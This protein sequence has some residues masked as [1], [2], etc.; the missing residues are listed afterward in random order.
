MHNRRRLTVSR[1][2]YVSDHTD[3]EKI[4]QPNFTPSS[5]LNPPRASGLRI[6]LR[7][8]IQR[9]PSRKRRGKMTNNIE[10]IWIRAL[11]NYLASLD[12]HELRRIRG[13]TSIQG[14][15]SDIQVLQKQYAGRAS[16]RCFDRL[17]P[18]LTW[19]ESFNKCVQTFINVSPKAFVLL[20]GSLS[21]ALEVRLCVPSTR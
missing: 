13:V 21:F 4:C 15:M 2:F 3:S 10:I 12:D 6:A 14:L 16:A 19:L 20:W 1:K 8:Q 5:F 17:R 7:S 9:A 18:I 11:D